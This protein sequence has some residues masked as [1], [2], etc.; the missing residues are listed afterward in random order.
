MPHTREEVFA[1]LSQLTEQ[2]I[3]ARLADGIYDAEKAKFVQLYLDEQELMRTHAANPMRWFVPLSEPVRQVGIPGV[4]ARGDVGSFLPF[5]LQPLAPC[6]V[7]VSETLIVPESKTAEGILIAANS[8]AFLNLLRRLGA[9]PSAIYE[10][11]WRQ[12]EELMAAAYYE[13]GYE[14]TLTS[15]SGD[16]GRDLIAVKRGRGCIRVINQV[17]RYSPDHL[18]TAEQARSTLGVLTGDHAASKAVLTTTSGFAPRIL[19]DPA[20]GP[21][22]P[23]RL[24]LIDGEDLQKLFKE[25]ERG[26]ADL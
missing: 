18:V 6:P 25:L 26:E 17:K 15:R 19:D 7:L 8:H 4:T 20:I 10:L 21:A 1:E 16:H 22:V 3:Q 23:T 9:D 11:D 24:Q 12:L 5:I 2:D 14:V 13:C